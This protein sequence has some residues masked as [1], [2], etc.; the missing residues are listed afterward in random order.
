M[1]KPKFRLLWALGV[2]LLVLGLVGAFA[3]QFA[4]SR[5]GGRHGGYGHGGHYTGHRCFIDAAG[6]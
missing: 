4:E 3:P 1:K 6:G 5:G 2:A